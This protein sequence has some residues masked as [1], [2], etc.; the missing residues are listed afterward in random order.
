MKLAF[1]YKITYAYLSIGILWILFSDTLLNIFIDDKNI[2]TQ[3]Q[4]YKGWFYVCVT[5]FLFF[6]FIKKHLYKLRNTEQELESHKQHLQELVIE[7]TQELDAAIIRL[8]S[9]NQELETKNEIINSQNI[10][11][12]NTMKNHQ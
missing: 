2:L 3:I 6:I 8:R 12:K 4:T 1:E 7:K 5:A 9:I 10:D 11:L